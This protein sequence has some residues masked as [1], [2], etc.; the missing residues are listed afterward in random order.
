MIG[1]ICD[2]D[3]V[4]HGKRK[5]LYKNWEWFFDKD[6]DGI[7][8][9]QDK[10]YKQSRN[11]DSHNKRGGHITYRQTLVPKR[12]NNQLLRKNQKRKEF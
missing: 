2:T 4:K 5:K 11:V 1:D 7:Y 3:P 12:R 9:K 8:R 10:Q 6:E